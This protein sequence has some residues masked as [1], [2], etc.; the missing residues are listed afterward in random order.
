MQLTINL[1]KEQIYYLITESSK[2]KITKEQ[3]IQQLLN[4]QIEIQKDCEGSMNVDLWD[5]VED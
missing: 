2:Q 4:I 3:L 5:T 1:T